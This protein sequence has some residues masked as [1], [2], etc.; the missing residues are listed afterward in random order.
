MNERPW[1]VVAGPLTYNTDGL[2]TM[3]S[4]DFR[5]EPK[6]AAAYALGAASGHGFGRD[7]HIEWRVFINCWAAEHALGIPGDFVECGTD[8]G[9]IARAVTSFTS[10]ENVDKRYYLLDTFAGFPE[11]QLTD[12]ERA[13]GLGDQHETYA[14]TYKNVVDYFKTYSNVTIIRGKV[15]DTL[16]QCKAE[17]ISYLSIDMNAVVPEIAAATAFWDR[18]SP[19]AFVV[20]DDYGWTFHEEQRLAFDAFA[21]ERGTRVLALPTGQGLLVKP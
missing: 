18:L 11:G 20:L 5:N 3:H 4:A 19:G 17:R 1:K 16:G 10:F 9:I 13:R 12:A 8:T 14:D 15:P 6:F 2:A 7:L 21:K